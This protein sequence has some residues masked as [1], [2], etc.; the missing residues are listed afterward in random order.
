MVRSVKASSVVYMC[1][2]VC[3]RAIRDRQSAKRSRVP[4]VHAAGDLETRGGR[5]ATKKQ[6][7]EVVPQAA[8]DLQCRYLSQPPFLEFCGGLSLTSI[9]HAQGRAHEYEAELGG[10]KSII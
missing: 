6:I 5:D 1:V 2:Y 8:S 4:A 9:S 3:A 7:K 10:K